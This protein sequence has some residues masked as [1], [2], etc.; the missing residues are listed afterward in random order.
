MNEIFSFNKS[1]QFPNE[2]EK[3]SDFFFW[4]SN[5]T[6]KG[7][8]GKVLFLNFGAFFLKKGAIIFTGIR[9]GGGEGGVKWENFEME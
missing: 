6:I 9:G 3:I 4:N 2:G 5:A 1:H 8:L 7:S